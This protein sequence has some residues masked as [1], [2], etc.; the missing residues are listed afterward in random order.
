[1]ARGGFVAV[2]HPGS[3]IQ[4][5]PGSS[6]AIPAIQAITLQALPLPSPSRRP[7]SAPITTAPPLG[8]RGL[9]VPCTL[10]VDEVLD[11][12]AER[13]VE[14]CMGHV[15]ARLGT[16]LAMGVHGYG[17]IHRMDS[18]H[19]LK[20]S[21]AQ[22]CL[23]VVGVVHGLILYGYTGH[24]LWRPWFGVGLPPGTPPLWLSPHSTSIPDRHSRIGAGLK[25]FHSESPPLSH[26]LAQLS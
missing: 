9:G 1:M 19:A 12:M 14:A 17:R 21:G 22:V 18:W 2:T 24:S 25:L 7:C 3:S 10:A 6:R 13:R 5:L 8:G 15:T 16:A 20:A 26:W 4:G 11:A 23:G